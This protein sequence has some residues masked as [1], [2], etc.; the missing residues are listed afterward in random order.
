MGKH[1]AIGGSGIG[2]WAECPGSVRLSKDAQCTPPSPYMIEG[3]N[4]HKLAELSFQQ[5]L[6][7]SDVEVDF[8]VPEDRLEA[9]RLYVQTVRTDEALEDVVWRGVEFRVSLTDLHPELYGTGDYGF[10][11]QTG[12]LFVYDYKSGAGHVVESFDQQKY[13]ALGALKLARQDI[14]GITDIE[15]VVVQPR[16][17]HPDGPVRRHRMTAKDL[18]QWQNEFL[19]P[20]A[21]ATDDPG[22][23]LVPGEHCHFCKAIS[24]CPALRGQMLE[25]A[26]TTFTEIQ[27]DITLPNPEEL[28]PEQL[29]RVLDFAGI[30]G[31]WSREVAGHAQGLL[32]SGHEIPGYKLV[33]KKAQRRWSDEAAFIAAFEGGYGDELYTKKLISPAQAEKIIGKKEVKEYWESIDT[34]LTIAPESDR[35]KAVAALGVFDKID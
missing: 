21:K 13:Y 32:E 20:A 5:G 15:L 10:S 1:S 31:A 35:R 34:G 3:T 22:A 2:I 4:D 8:D 18:Y 7:P 9:V 17:Y 27:D 11:T 33:N 30:I 23:L 24:F 28:S 29:A 25:L 19:I 6:D 16:A 12:C 26:Q 14:N